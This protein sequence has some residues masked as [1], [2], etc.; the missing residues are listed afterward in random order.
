MTK[1][2]VFIL[3]KRSQKNRWQI[4]YEDDFEGIIYILSVHLVVNHTGRFLKVIEKNCLTHPKNFTRRFLLTQIFISLSFFALFN[5]FCTF[6][7]LLK[8]T[9][10]NWLFFNHTTSTPMTN[11][12]GV[13]TLQL[14]RK[15]LHNQ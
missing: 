12:D 5:V 8:C 15:Y 14:S 9:Q 7:Q 2:C 3:K 1:E 6:H 13:Q 10:G 4:N 11:D